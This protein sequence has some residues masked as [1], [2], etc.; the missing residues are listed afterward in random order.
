MR[1]L[2]M[3]TGY[4]SQRYQIADIERLPTRGTVIDDARI[5]SEGHLGSWVYFGRGSDW[6]KG[7][8][9]RLRMSWKTAARLIIRGAWAF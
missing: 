2:A 1:L 3:R 8:S 9:T 6:S 4:I 7:I 5:G